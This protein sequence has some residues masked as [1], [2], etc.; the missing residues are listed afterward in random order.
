MCPLHGCAPRQCGATIVKEKKSVLFE[1]LCQGRYHYRNY[2]GTACW[3]AK[4]SDLST[5]SQDSGQLDSDAQRPLVLISFMILPIRI[6]PPL[7]L[8]VPFSA[9]TPV[10]KVRGIWH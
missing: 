6:D 10:C 7:S 5:S 1:W 4:F 8:M 3:Q 9:L 2:C